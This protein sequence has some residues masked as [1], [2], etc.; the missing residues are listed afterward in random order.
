MFWNNIILDMNIIHLCVARVTRRVQQLEQELL[1]IP[2]HRRSAPVLSG[3]R[4]VLSLVFCVVLCRSLSFFFWSLYC[5]SF[6][7]VCY[8]DFNF[9]IFKLFLTQKIKYVIQCERLFFSDSRHRARSYTND[10]K[11]N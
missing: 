7:Y 10:L 9:R 5:L 2:E 4:V 11:S 1:T 8:S 3:T 6:F